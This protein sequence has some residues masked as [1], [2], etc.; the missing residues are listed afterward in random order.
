L[1]SDKLRAEISTTSRDRGDV[2]LALAET[3]R[4]VEAQAVELDNLKA[5]HSDAE[6][7]NEASKQN[8]QCAEE[9][10]ISNLQVYYT[11]IHVV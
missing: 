8:A 2:F 11:V 9:G 10:I 7:T 3:K 4:T 5:R 6:Q 1:I